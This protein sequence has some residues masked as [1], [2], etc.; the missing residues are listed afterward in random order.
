M[1]EGPPPQDAHANAHYQSFQH[2]V[3]ALLNTVMEDHPFAATALKNIEHDPSFATRLSP[4]SD[5]WRA[6]NSFLD[7]RG[8]SRTVRLLLK[9]LQPRLDN[10]RLDTYLQRNLR[11]FGDLNDELA[12]SHVRNI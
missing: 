10:K 2:R 5:A 6:L 7:K 11:A 4:G 9:H 12:L 1:L 3:L 8:V